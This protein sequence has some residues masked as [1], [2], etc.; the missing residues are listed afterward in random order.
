M[1]ENGILGDALKIPFPL[2]FNI[3]RVFAKKVGLKIPGG[4][5][6]VCELMQIHLD[7]DSRG[8]WAPKKA[9]N[10]VMQNSHDHLQF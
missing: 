4:I 5:L 3:N 7:M 10:L 1:G 9:K 8:V 2:F 6:T